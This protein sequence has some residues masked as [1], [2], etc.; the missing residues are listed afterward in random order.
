MF[1]ID[2]SCKD[3]GNTLPLYDHNKRGQNSG[4]WI[5]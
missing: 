4:E 5:L 3:I 1:D 2:K